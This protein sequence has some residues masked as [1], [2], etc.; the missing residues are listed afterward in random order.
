MCA[1]PPSARPPGRPNRLVAKIDTQALRLGIWL[2]SLIFIAGTWI[3]EEGSNQLSIYSSSHSPNE[4]YG[5][6]V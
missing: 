2:E 1:V 4:A 6:G 5:A 3:I